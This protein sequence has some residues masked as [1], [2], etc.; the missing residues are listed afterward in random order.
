MEGPID[1]LRSIAERL[2]NELLLYSLAVCVIAALATYGFR[3]RGAAS[4][5]APLFVIV[6]AFGGPILLRNYFVQEEDAS[7]A[8]T[9]LNV[10]QTAHVEFQMEP[11]S[12]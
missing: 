6:I 1:L 12:E 7:T 9:Y 8:E 11:G 2:S 5:M 4:L 3:R 10:T